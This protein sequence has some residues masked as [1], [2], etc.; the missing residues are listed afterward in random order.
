MNQLISD[1]KNLILIISLVLIIVLSF[2]F[3][4]KPLANKVKNTYQNYLDKNATLATLEEK[5]ETLKE[6]QDIETE[7]TEANQNFLKFIPDEQESEDIM[8]SLDALARQTSNILPS[9]SVSKEDPTETSGRIAKRNIEITLGGTFANILD[10][11]QKAENLQRF[12]QIDSISLN[13]CPQT[14]NIN[15]TIKLFIFYKK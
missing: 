12:N 9:F 3:I 7:I 11:I 13:A 6:F 10:F 2:I 1:K 14:G 8:V 5:Y 4:V 15:T